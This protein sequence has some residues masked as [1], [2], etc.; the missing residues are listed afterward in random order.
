MGIMFII[1]IILKS[2]GTKLKV[3]LVGTGGVGAAIAKIANQRDPKGKWLDL[4]VLA[5]RSA[6]K[7]ESLA[8]IIGNST[9]FPAVHLDASNK[10]ETIALIEKYNI[11]LLMN[12][13]DPTMN[14]ILF[15]T[16]FECGIN[17][18]DTAMT[19]SVPHP[20]DPYN[21]THIKMG[22]Y[23]FDKNSQWEDKGIMALL[24]MGI[25]PG[26][27]NVF[28]KYAEKHFFDEIDEISIKDGG[29]LEAEG[30]DVSFGFSIWTT[31]DECLNPP[32]IWEKDKGWYTKEP[33]S[34][35][36]KFTFPAG[37]GEQELVNVEHEEV[38]MLP[39][40]IGKGCKKITFK[41]GLGEEFI[42]MLKNLRALNL[43]D[44]H[45]KIAGT[46]LSPRD[47]VAQ[48][49][50]NP[51]EIADKLKG[52]VCVGAYVEGKKNGYER[53]VYIYQVTDNE[54][55]MARIGSQAVVGQTGY[56]PVIAM[57]L[58]AKGIWKDIGVVCP[59][60]FDPDPYIRLMDEYDYYAG[61][62]E[63]ESEYKRMLDKSNLMQPLL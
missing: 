28:A 3:L 63:M 19:L 44:K 35:N 29:N 50:P 54:E 21:K 23:Q 22:D 5:N 60:A 18:M 37:I 47:I 8:S 20:E 51:T 12:A 62:V 46:N 24:G 55:I 61:I 13:C 11:D 4:M 1:N 57:E 38:L 43:D 6:G 58:M 2:G 40:Y 59:E 41:Y 7:A 14:E 52:K 10:D 45:K 16:A 32:F 33:F 26:C 31:I 27:S 48:V 25:D 56:N 36:E 49:A 15:D 30:Y 34:D 17:Y 9:R 39:R 42:T 53:K